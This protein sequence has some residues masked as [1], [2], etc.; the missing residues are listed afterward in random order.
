MGRLSPFSPVLPFSRSVDP[1][2]GARLADLLR[3]RPGEAPAISALAPGAAP[4]LVVA[5]DGSSVKLAEPGG[6]LLAAYRAAIVRVARDGNAQQAQAAEVALLGPDAAET[7][8]ERLGLAME[9]PRLHPEAAL[10]AL[11][12]L[13]EI[14]AAQRALDDMRPGDLLLLDGPLQERPNVPL[15]E[16]LLAKARAGRVDV[17]GVC[18]STSLQVG[19]TP[20]LPA[21]LGAARALGL[22]TWSSPLPAP[23]NVRGRVYAARLSS[24]EPRA[25]R[26]DVSSAEGDDLRVLSSIAALCGHPAYPGYPSPLAMAHN[27]AVLDEGARSR[28]LAQVEDAALRAGVRPSEW[29]A[30]CVDYHDVLELGA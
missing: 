21:C 7:L 1:A 16:T 30:A 23:A 14:R 15:M 2:L 4:R 19:R 27:A 17:A 22:S 26:F 18:K 8:R 9:I 20:A 11:R 10:D 24:A 5:V 28:L 25:F 13:A 12:T 3:P 29:E 6:H